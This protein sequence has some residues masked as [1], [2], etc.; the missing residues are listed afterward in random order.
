L[1]VINRLSRHNRLLPVI[2]QGQL[3][4]KL[5]STGHRNRRKTKPYQ[6]ALCFSA[7]SVP[8]DKCLLLH[9]IDWSESVLTKIIF[10]IKYMTCKLEV[11]AH[12]CNPSYLKAEIGE[13]EGLSPNQA[14]TWWDAPVIL[15]MREVQIVG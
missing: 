14:S 5:W 13:D 1:S 4:Q 9:S 11:V 8:T 12:T 3:P 7:V 6:A 10:N 2:G 15:A